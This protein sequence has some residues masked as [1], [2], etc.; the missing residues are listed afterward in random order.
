MGSMSDAFLGPRFDYL[1][2]ELSGDLLPEDPFE[3]LEVW[4][5]EA[6]VGGEREP[7][8]MALSTVSADGHPS[9]RMV[10][11]RGIDHGLAFYTNY[12]SRK[13]L[14]LA[15]NPRA[16]GLFWWGE[17]Q[18]RVEGTVEKLTA[19]QSDAYFSSRPLDS[20]LASA[21][22]PQSQEIETREELE[23][24]IDA[25]RARLAQDPEGRD[26]PARPEH[27]GGYR[28]VPDRI[29][30]WQGRAAR[31]HDRFVYERKGKGWRVARLAP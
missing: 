22:S 10:L 11:V 27:W 9:S 2:D 30:F 5:A 13:G 29:E 26:A 28:L 20:Q 25:L 24:E 17:R 21:V 4:L 3:L 14:E 7:T 23:S 19:E 12:L 8:A 1:R 31:L 18:V 15:G 6:A 16:S